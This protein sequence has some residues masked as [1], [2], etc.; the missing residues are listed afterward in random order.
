MKPLILMVE[1]DAQN[2]GKF[3]CQP[4]GFRTPIVT[5]LLGLPS[6]LYRAG[7]ND[8]CTT[9]RQPHVAI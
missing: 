5:S 4:F 2:A 6:Y 9:L 3:T 1:D 7:T 8:P